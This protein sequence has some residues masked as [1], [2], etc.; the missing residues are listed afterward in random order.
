MSRPAAVRLAETARDA[1][2]AAGFADATC[3]RLSTLTGREGVCVRP[4]AAETVEAYMDGTEVKRVVLSVVA[5]SRSA[6]RAMEDAQE[7]ASVAAD[8]ID[9]ASVA[10]EARELKLEEEGFYAW[11]AQVEALVEEGCR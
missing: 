7:A 2:I 1:A 4:L 9:G 3:E 8:A 11:E 5:R 6:A 10:H